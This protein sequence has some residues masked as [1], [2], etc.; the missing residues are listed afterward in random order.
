MTLQQLEQETLEY[1]MARMANADRWV[2]ACG[3]KETPFTAKSGKRLLYCWNP[4]QAKHAYIDVGAD[5]LLTDDEAR[6]HMGW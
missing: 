2:P 6:A 3:G 1:S 4:Q 5:M